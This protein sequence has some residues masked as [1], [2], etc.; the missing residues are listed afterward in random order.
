MYGLKQAGRGWHQELTKG[1]TSNVGLTQSSIDH[2]V[3]YRKQSQEHMILAVVTNNILI[4]SK[5][6]EDIVVF[7]M[8][9]VVVK[10]A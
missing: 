5:Q 10:E 3:F 4:M 2:S 6:L 9:V 1:F 8:E 7:K